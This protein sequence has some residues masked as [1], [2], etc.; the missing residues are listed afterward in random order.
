M[1]CDERH[2]CDCAVSIQPHDDLSKRAL[3]H[4]SNRRLY[5]AAEYTDPVDDDRGEPAVLSGRPHATRH[6]SVRMLSLDQ[7]VWRPQETPD[8]VCGCS[9]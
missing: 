6:G 7:V 8:A 2:W 9:A 5:D 1:E 3:A 4:V